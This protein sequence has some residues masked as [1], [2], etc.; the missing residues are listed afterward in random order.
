MLATLIDQ[1]FSREGWLFETKF[2]GVRC[3]V[4][5]DGREVRISSRN[6]KLLNQRYPELVAV[7]EA[8]P[9]SSF[10]ADGEIVTFAGEVTSFAKLQQRMQVRQ[11]SAELR[12]RIPVWFY[13]F[14]LLY[15][16][17]YD[18]RQVALRDRKQLLRKV[19]A[20]DDPLRFCE[21]RETEG[22]AYYQQACSQGWEGILAKNGD[23]A[24]VSGRSREWLKFKCV[25]EQEFVI[26]GYTDPQGQRVGFG[27]LQVGYYEAGVLKYAG[28]VGT[29]YDNVQLRRLE[30][31][32]ERLRIATSPFADLS[33]SSPGV[34]WVKPELVAQ[35][36]FAEWTTDAKLRH[37]RFVG[38]RDDKR[39]EEVV[40]E[41]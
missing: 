16:G 38:L 24:Y 23:S 31:Q 27:A 2:D 39:P 21:H 14:D 26:G 35:I 29:G 7:F 4:F 6:Q 33:R 15:L 18:L 5:R 40:R 17:E 8:Q 12:R 20:F 11:P 25:N 30:N 9:A 36:G 34:H 28:K 10:I 3:L 19:F 32:L 13:V 1:R 41:K 22:E 37:P